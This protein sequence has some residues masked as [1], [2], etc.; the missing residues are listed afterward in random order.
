L[1]VNSC[2]G[3]F[4]S[5]PLGH[6]SGGSSAVER[7]SKPTYLVFMNELTED[8]VIY[9]ANYGMCE[10]CDLCGRFMGYIN[11][12]ENDSYIEFNGVQFLCNK[13]RS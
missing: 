11:Y 1:H 12:N 10:E 9:Y 6:L 2:V 3:V 13:C 4:E 8:E 7:G 5:T